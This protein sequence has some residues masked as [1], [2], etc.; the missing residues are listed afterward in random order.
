MKQ[1]SAKLLIL[2][3]SVCLSAVGFSSFIIGDVSN[4]KYSAKN[5]I[6]EEP[7]AKIL[8]KD[9]FYTTI[10]KALDDAIDGDIVTILP[11]NDSNYPAVNSPDKVNVTINRN[12]TIKPGVTL[13]IPTD[14]NSITYAETDLD[15]YVESMQNDDHSRTA[16]DYGKFATSN[17]SRYLRVSVTV[18]KNVKVNNY[19]KIIVSGYLGGGNNGFGLIGQTTNSYSRILLDENAQIIQKTDNNYN[20]EN[21]TIYCYGY[22]SEKNKDNNSLVQISNGSLYVPFIVNDYRAFQFSWSMTGKNGALEKGCSPFNQFEF[23]NIDSKVKIDYESSIYGIVNAYM[24]YSAYSIKQN[25]VKVINLIGHTSDFV[26]QLSNSNIRNI[27]SC[28]EY[29]YDIDTNLASLDFYGG[30]TLNNLEIVFEASAIGVSVSVVLSTT[31]SFF[32]L[33]YRFKIGLN[34]LVGQEVCTYNLNNQK[35][36]LLPGCEVNINDGCI[37]EASELIVYDAFCDGDLGNGVGKNNF[38]DSVKYPLLPGAILRVSD[39]VAIDA[40]SIAGTVYCDEKSNINY[41]VGDTLTSL[42]AWEFRN[43]PDFDPL[44]ALSTKEPAWKICEFLYVKEKLNIVPI[45]NLNKKKIHIALNTFDENY[46]PGLEVIAFTSNGTEIRSEVNDYQCTLFYDDIESYKIDFKKN[47]S[48]VLINKTKYE[49]N[50]DIGFNSENA[51]LNTI[52]SA[53]SISSNLNGVNE[54]NAQSIEIECMTDLINGVVPL[55]PDKTI[56]LKAN[57]IDIN[58]IYDKNIYWKS[59]TPETVSV[60][61]NGIVKGLSLG[62]AV[63]QATCDGLTAEFKTEVIEESSVDI[64]DLTSVVVREKSSGSVEKFNVKVNEKSRY[65]FEAI[66]GEDGAPITNIKRTLA[67]GNLGVYHNIVDPI[68]NEITRST[69]LNTMNKEITLEFSPPGTIP[70]N[71]TLTCEVSNDLVSVSGEIAITLSEESSTCLLPYTKI[72]MKDLSWKYAKDLN[73]Q[74]EILTY[75]H[76]LGCFES[77]KVIF[78]AIY[79]GEFDIIDLY[80]EFDVHLK[81]ASGHGLFNMTHN[82]YEIYYGKDFIDHINEKFAVVKVKDGKPNICS[83]KLLKVDIYKEVITKYSPLS[84]YNV[85]CISDNVLT[86]PDDIEGMFDGFEFSND[87]LQINLDKFD[88]L[89]NKNG[90]YDYNEVKEVLPEYIFDVFNFKYFKTFIKA[91]YFT[92]EK[93]NYWLEKYGDEICDFHNI[94]FNFKNSKKLK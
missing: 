61:E 1:K 27:P 66:V 11:P 46:L 76:F 57:V 51:L 93:V 56:A 54:F 65:T 73:H 83:A 12:C 70:D 3:C 52:N 33:S 36:K 50:K 29:K 62:E 35:V 22:I 20:A 2:S 42:E 9:K 48:N 79:H 13:L 17:E 5:E 21:A 86:I 7:I 18:A 67:G 39:G 43:N 30:C 77:Q 14:N 63:I 69:V 82:K 49:K 8:G 45:E 15:G 84:E 38:Y 64:P 6:G 87:K 25:F 85:N 68:T 24:E 75:N 55:F 16:S 10:E 44:T 92:C 71:L 72:L 91:G 26:V 59:L 4:N 47:I 90:I 40:D 31:Q 81:V 53:V 94:A 32:P 60:D 19:G 41:S 80:F 74:D 89:A 58:K 78:N 28:L 88:D 37:L 34:K 23:R